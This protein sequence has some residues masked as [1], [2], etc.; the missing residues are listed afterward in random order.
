[1]SL[2]SE[3]QRAMFAVSRNSS[4]AGLWSGQLRQFVLYGAISVAALA[5]DYGLLIFLTETIGLYYLL[6]ATI[7]FMAGMLLVYFASV[8]YIFD[9]RRLGNRSL[10]LTSF[11][12]IGVAGLVLNALLLWAITSGTPLGYQLAKL[13]TAGIVFLFNY[14]ARRNLLFSSE[15]S[16]KPTTLGHLIRPRR[17]AWLSR[18]GSATEVERSTVLMSAVAAVGVVGLW[19][20][21]HPYEGIIHDARLY[22]GHVLA[23]SDPNRVGQD[24]MFVLDGQFGFTV[25]PALL[26]GAIDTFGVSLGS[27][28]ISLVG[29]L[30]WIGALA[31]LAASMARGRERL[32]IM[33]FVVVLPASYGGFHVFQYAEAMATPRLFSEAGVLLAFALLC[34]GRKYWALLP[35][36]IAALLHPIMALPALGVWAWLVLFDPEERVVP[37]KAGLVIAG[38]GA[39]AVLLAAAFQGPL[40]ERLFVAVAPGLSE[41][42]SARTPDLF[43]AQWPVQDWS[44][45]VVQ[46]ATLAI[47]ARIVEGRVR[48]L[49]IA[50]LIIGVGG[51]VSVHVLGSLL[52]SL[53]AIQAQ[54]WRSVW[55]VAVLSGAALAI[56][57]VRL[58][59]QG[60]NARITL[61]S[62]LVAW[63]SA[64]TP[65]LALPAVLAA[66]IF[67][68]WPRVRDLRVEPKLMLALWGFVG[69]YAL[70]IF[71][72]RLYGLVSFAADAPDGSPHLVSLLSMFA[73]LAVPV[74][75]L[76]LAYA[77]SNPPER[78]LV[79]PL[80][81]SVVLG[82][83][84]LAFWDVRSERTIVADQASGDPALRARLS[85]RSGDVL[86]LD[87]RFETWSLAGRPNWIS[88]LQGSSAVFSRSLADIWDRRSRF[89]TDLGVVDH[90]LRTPFAV[91]GPTT[92][93]EPSLRELTDTKLAR[94][95][96]L[97]DAPAWLIMPAS[98]FASGEVSAERWPVTSW[99]AVGPVTSFAWD[100]K[101]VSW[102][103]TQDYV[104]IPCAS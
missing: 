86:W 101:A 83:L 13:P 97:P 69:C 71:G 50:T 61:G 4:F 57:G 75:A 52:G 63:L 3:R 1:M 37:L 99:R 24:I 95:C 60:G 33:L 77:L 53:L 76:A 84:A 27:K 45:V 89:L 56:C 90:R 62:L 79:L 5:V 54:L 8:S 96:A 78:R 44:R 68:F 22:V 30:A 74:C 26:A 65:E 41:I 7:S 36:V 29:L 72:M 48:S 35:L 25:F 12:A 28:L 64:E 66:M 15:R 87:G 58:W 31:C 59:K 38:I 21:L 11:V 73:V 67:A 34:Q 14:L 91:E 46:M 100:G 98:A 16:S 40:V 55:V 82:L 23:A 32:A 20:L 70:L 43:P 49:F 42:L 85:S 2:E 17:P 18:S 81:A 51:L 6:S 94:L 80:G 93:D 39:A 104:V 88:T 92:N 9:E 47:A 103:A 10:E 19:F 102:T